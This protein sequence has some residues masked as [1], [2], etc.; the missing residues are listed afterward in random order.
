MQT[1]KA[2]E[3]HYVLTQDSP[4]FSVDPDSANTDVACVSITLFCYKD[5]DHPGGQCGFYGLGCS[6]GNTVCEDGTVY[7]GT[8]RVDRGSLQQFCLD[9]CEG[10]HAYVDITYGD[11]SMQCETQCPEAN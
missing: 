5:P 8:V 3:T 9:A 11:Q 10:S 4:C 2:Q 6:L 1:A 7:G